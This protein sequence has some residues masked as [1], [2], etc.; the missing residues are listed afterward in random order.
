M[1]DIDRGRLG[2]AASKFPE[3]ATYTDFRKLLD[4]QKS[5]DAVV[6]STPDHT[7]APAGGTGHAA[8][9]ALLL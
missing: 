4:E 3:A 5:L 8:G 7:H 1:C 9:P 2:G 6:V